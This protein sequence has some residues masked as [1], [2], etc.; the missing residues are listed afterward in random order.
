M[1]KKLLIVGM[2][3]LNGCGLITNTKIVTAPPCLITPFPTPPPALGLPYHVQDKKE[4]V[5]AVCYLKDDDY[6]MTKFLK[7]V[8][9]WRNEVRSCKAIKETKVVVKKNNYPQLM[10][11]IMESFHG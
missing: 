1:L 7:Q 2:L 5:E 8:A 9:R 10:F 6:E 11:A 3:F 4:L